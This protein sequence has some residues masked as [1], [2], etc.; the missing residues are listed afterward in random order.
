MA[1]AVVVAFQVMSE[2]NAAP[3]GS[4]TIPPEVFIKRFPE[5]AGEMMLSPVKVMVAEDVELMTD[6][7]PQITVEQ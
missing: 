7:V 4:A 6:S 1:A 2:V 3:L 5:F